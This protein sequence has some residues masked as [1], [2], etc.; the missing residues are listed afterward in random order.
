MSVADDRTR[1]FERA[2]LPHLDAAWNF[3][4]W[5]MRSPS[6]AEDVL[7]DAY[8]RA[9]KYFDSHHGNTRAWLLAIVRRDLGAIDARIVEPGEEPPAGAFALGCDL[10]GDRTARLTAHRVKLC[11][12]PLTSAGGC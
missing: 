7:Q 11:T 3:A 6:D 2:A 9:F 8:L 1:R 4:R 10:P 12:D 5:L